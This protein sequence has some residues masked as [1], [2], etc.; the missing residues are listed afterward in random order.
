MLWVAG[1]SDAKGFDVC[2][3]Q[4][5]AR[6]LRAG[7]SSL[8]F[9]KALLEEVGVAISHGGGFGKDGDDSVRFAFI[10]DIKNMEIVVNNIK[11]FLDKK[12]TVIAKFKRRFEKEGIDERSYKMLQLQVLELLVVG[13]LI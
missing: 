2:M 8:D 6:I 7:M 13:S 1:Y 11:Q 9:T 3:G 5:T 12:E 4:D 10:E